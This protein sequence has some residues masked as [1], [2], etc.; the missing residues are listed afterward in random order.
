MT[1]ATPSNPESVG[2]LCAA[3]RDRYDRVG[4]VAEA[5]IDRLKRDESADDLLASLDDLVQR[6]APDVQALSAWAG[7]GEVELLNQT[8]AALTRGMAA[9]RSAQEEATRSLARIGG[10]MDGAIQGRKGNRAYRT[11]TDSFDLGSR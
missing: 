9:I 6:S 8:R 3:L 4:A 2:L 10:E 5:A 11:N 7:S 1:L